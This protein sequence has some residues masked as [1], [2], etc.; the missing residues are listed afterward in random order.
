MPVYALGDVEPRIHPDAYVHPDAVVI[1]D[2][3]I[4]AES[5]VWPG[6]VIR[7]DDGQILI[8]ERT[9]IQDG[10]VLHTTPVFFTTVGN[11]C[12]IGHLVHLEGCIVEDGALVGNGSVVLHEARIC[13]GAVV[14]SGALVPGRMVVPPRAMALGIPAKIREDAAD[15]AMIELARDSY[16]RR[17]ARYR[18]ELRRLD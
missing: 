5:S 6:A 9:S 14:G 1:G 13:S 2:V 17:I 15:P 10:C 12:V 8:G 3:T 16:V 7:G 4:G 18:A 11:D